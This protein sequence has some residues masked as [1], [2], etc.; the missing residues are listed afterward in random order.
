MLRINYKNRYMLFN[1][2]CC[3]AT[4][5]FISINSDS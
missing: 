2:N 3:H 4:V 1:N 5:V